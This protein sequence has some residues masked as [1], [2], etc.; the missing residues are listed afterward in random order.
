MWMFC[1]IQEYIFEQ[2]T[3]T[4]KDALVKLNKSFY[5]EV[6]WLKTLGYLFVDIIH[7]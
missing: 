4:W 6:I 1:A 3:R 7:A 5:E 2:R